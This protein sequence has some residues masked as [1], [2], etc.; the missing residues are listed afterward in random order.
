MKSAQIKVICLNVQFSEWLI[1]NWYFVD[2]SFL[3][4]IL[5][6]VKHKVYGFVI[7]L[8]LLSQNADWYY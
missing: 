1:A 2:L 6:W 8:K 5:N 3:I 7:G 4:A